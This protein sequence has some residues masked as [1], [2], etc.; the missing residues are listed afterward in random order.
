MYERNEFSNF[1]VN[2]DKRMSAPWCLDDDKGEDWYTKGNGI[3]VDFPKVQTRGTSSTEDEQSW[4]NYD[5]E[6]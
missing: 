5:E 3:Y 4:I 6:F 1:G 2:G